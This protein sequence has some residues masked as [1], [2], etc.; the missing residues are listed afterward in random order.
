[1]ASHYFLDE[2]PAVNTQ[3]WG[4]RVLW[5]DGDEFV[6]EVYDYLEWPRNWWRVRLPLD[7]IRHPRQRLAVVRPWK[8]FPFPRITYTVET[9]VVGDVTMLRKRIEVHVPGLEP[10]SHLMFTGIAREATF[11]T[12][13]ASPSFTRF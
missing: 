8:A 12:P 9:V 5:C 3:E 10:L 1:M 11:G 13:V 2:L 7:L 6:A 4:G